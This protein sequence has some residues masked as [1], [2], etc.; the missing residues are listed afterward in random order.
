[1]QSSKVCSFVYAQRLKFEVSASDAFRKRCLVKNL[2]LTLVDDIENIY[3]RPRAEA[4]LS[5]R[6]L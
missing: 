1:M 3:G 6:G 4:P 5:W 2:Y